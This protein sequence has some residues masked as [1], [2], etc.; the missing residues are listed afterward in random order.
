MMANNAPMPGQQAQ[1]IADYQREERLKQIAEIKF[2]EDKPA[3]NGMPVRL[4]WDKAD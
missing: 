3:E 1:K 2:M 4:T